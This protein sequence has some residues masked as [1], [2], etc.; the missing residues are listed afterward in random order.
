MLCLSFPP[1]PAQGLHVGTAGFPLWSHGEHKFGITSMSD[2]AVPTWM[3]Q[4]PRGRCFSFAKLQ[5]ILLAR[6][7]SFSC[8]Y[9]YF[10]L[11]RLVRASI[12]CHH[13][14]LQWPSSKGDKMLLYYKSWGKIYIKVDVL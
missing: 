6:T 11:P 13:P 14:S 5:C 1:F 9:Y 7:E 12:H 3:G 2:N 8:Y 10:F 4:Q